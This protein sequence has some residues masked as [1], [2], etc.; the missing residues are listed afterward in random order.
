MSYV[1]AAFGVTLATLFGYALRL[2]A[3][4]RALRREISRARPNAG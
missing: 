1:L 3:E 4:A 2:A